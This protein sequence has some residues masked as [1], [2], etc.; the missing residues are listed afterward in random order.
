MTKI[1]TTAFQKVKS[2]SAF[3]WR[4]FNRKDFQ[5]K[6]KALVS[7]GLIYNL[8]AKRC[9]FTD[10]TY[11]EFFDEIHNFSKQN[12]KERIRKL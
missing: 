2:G 5:S 8:N 3:T 10:R 6:E 12:E 7:E 4:K 1:Y 9:G 11:K